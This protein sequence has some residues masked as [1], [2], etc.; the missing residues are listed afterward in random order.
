ME[1]NGKFEFQW[2]YAEPILSPEDKWLICPQICS[3]EVTDQQ[4]SYCTYKCTYECTYNYVNIYVCVFVYLDL[5]EYQC[6][7]SK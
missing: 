2:E 5:S 7:M 6:T 3:K 4:Y 1:K